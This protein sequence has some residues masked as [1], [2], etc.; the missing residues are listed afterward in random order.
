MRLNNS[1]YLD[2][3]VEM[4]E[5]V[6]DNSKELRKGLNKKEVSSSD[7]SEMESELKKIDNKDL[8]E[9]LK[10]SIEDKKKG[11]GKELVVKYGRLILKESLYK[12]M[13]QKI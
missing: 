9:M 7:F 2:E 10:K 1:K 4:L 5:Y 11:R 3:M 13:K 12:K 6:V 8:K